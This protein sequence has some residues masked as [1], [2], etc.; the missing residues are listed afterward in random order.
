MKYGLL[1][2]GQHSHW[3]EF[4]TKAASTSGSQCVVPALVSASP[5]DILEM[6][7][8]G[9]QCRSLESDSRGGVF[10]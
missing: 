1:M 5:G 6:Q 8:L 9:F 10:K 2:D 3:P 4:V 7:V